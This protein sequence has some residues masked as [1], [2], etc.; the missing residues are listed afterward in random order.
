[1]EIKRLVNRPC[2]SN[3]IRSMIT[4]P[5]RPDPDQNKG[6]FAAY[7]QFMGEGL[8]KIEQR[9]N[10]VSGILIINLPC[11]IVAAQSVNWYLINPTKRPKWCV[12][13]DASSTHLV[14]V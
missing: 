10:K 4:A 5:H 7:V 14:C 1:M 11:L 2:A 8:I 13:A 3:D 9:K 12:L 6:D